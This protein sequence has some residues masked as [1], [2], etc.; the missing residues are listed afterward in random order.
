MKIL[1]INIISIALLILLASDLYALDTTHTHPLVTQRI[2]ELIKISD[3]VEAYQDIYAIVPGAEPEARIFWG[4][5]FDQINYPSTASDT[6]KEDYLLDLVGAPYSQY[7]NVIDGVVQEDLP[8]TKVLDHFYHAETGKELSLNGTVL[9][10]S[11]PS[12]IVAMRYLN[13]SIQWMSGYETDEEDGTI[14]LKAKEYAFFVFGQALHHVEDMGSP[15]HVHNDAHLVLLET[16]KDDYESWYLPFLKINNGVGLNNFF[17]QYANETEANDAIKPVTNPWNNIWSNQPTS[18]VKYFYDRTLYTATL[19]F[20]LDQNIGINNTPKYSKPVSPPPPTGELSEMFPCENGSGGQDIDVPNCLH[21]DEEDLFTPAHWRINAVGE[22]QHQFVNGS[23]NDW[24]PVDV[25]NDHS[26]VTSGNPRS[27]FNGVSARYYIEQLSVG[28]TDGSILGVNLT[29]L[30]DI[31][32]VP[33][34]P[35]NMRTDFNSPWSNNPAANSKELRQIYAENLLSPIVEF[36]AGFTKYWY[37]IANTPPYL[38][39]LNVTQGVDVNGP[40]TVYHSAWIDKVDLAGVTVTN[41]ENCSVFDLICSEIPKVVAVVDSRTKETGSDSVKHIHNRQNLIIDF[42]FNEAMKEISS[43]RIGQYDGTGAC[44]EAS[45]GCLEITTPALFTS[46]DELTWSIVLLPAQLAGLNGKLQLTVNAIDK[47]NHSDG[48]DGLGGIDS[49]KGAELDATPDTPARR[50]ISFA[51]DTNGNPTTVNYYPW[52]KADGTG[53]TPDDIAYSY[54]P[55][56]GDQNHW[57]VFDT[58]KPSATITI[59]LPL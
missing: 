3:G 30:R 14:A 43:L 54:D 5:D 48:T 22:Y 47:N 32:G 23:D 31:D 57:L 6:V 7:N 17:T 42:T 58:G 34:A 25:E 2:G 37:D 20:P 1:N 21:W 26:P 27:S 45:S 18:M 4:T 16:E 10:G 13:Q 51:Q 29:F 38:K 39:S 55:E 12:A 56:N 52:H 49:G 9:P 36:G 33:V 28:N 8:A 40:K 53:D 59:T 46:S 19:E 41:V 24:W 35:K 11:E 50:D 44:I 15:A